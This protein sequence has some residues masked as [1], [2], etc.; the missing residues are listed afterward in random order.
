MFKRVPNEMSNFG[1]KSCG[2]AESEGSIGYTA[3]T[4]LF[5]VLA[6]RIKV[7]RNFVASSGRI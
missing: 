3:P 6:P 7:E 2:E 5:K 1:F 4:R